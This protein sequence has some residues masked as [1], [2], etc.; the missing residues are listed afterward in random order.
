MFVYKIGDRSFFNP[1]LA[2]L[3]GAEH[4]PD[5]LP[6][7]EFKDPVFDAIDWS[8]EPVQSMR[9]LVDLRVKQIAATY[10]RIVLAFS[11]G[12][13]SITVYSAFLRNN[14][15]IDEIIISYSDSE[16]E[17]LSYPKANAD[18]IRANHPDPRTK[19]T[20]LHRDD[21]TWNDNFEDNWILKDQGGLFRYRFSSHGNK[22]YRYC[23]D[24]WK[25]DNWCLITGHEKPHIIRQNGNWCAVHLD[26]VYR[27]GIGWPR[28]EYFFVSSSLPELHIK[29]NHALLKFIKSYVPTANEGWSSFGQ[30]GKSTHLDYTAFA[31]AC[32][33][34]TELTASASFLQKSTS[35]RLAQMDIKELMNKNYYSVAKFDTKLKSLLLTGETKALGYVNAWQSLHNDNTLVSYMLR[36][37]LL[38]SPTQDISDYAGFLGK[39]YILGT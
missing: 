19:I 12:T 3:Y 1:F 36:H 26:K 10:D 15:F 11:G 31:S 32:G 18:W 21:E 39:P 30:L 8:K 23:E 4:C 6:R 28:I 34:D 7:F 25:G 13:D 27:P 2:F 16:L 38:S 14:V 22:V 24:S 5:A 20:I 29:Q 9:E 35:I 33:R 37:S 17:S